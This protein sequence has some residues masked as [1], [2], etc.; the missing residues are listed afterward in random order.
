MGVGY[1]DFRRDAVYSKI[2][3]ATHVVK[4]LLSGNGTHNSSSP[5][6]RATNEFTVS[7][8]N[9]PLPLYSAGW[10]QVLRGSLPNPLSG[11]PNCSIPLE[12]FQ[13]ARPI[14]ARY[15]QFV[16]ETTHGSGRA[17]VLQYLGF[18]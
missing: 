16:A 4:E 2:N 14:E 11:N 3:L 8:S 18:E 17:P 1:S 15:V 10:F 6:Y 12:T 5:C 13:L 7:V 9:D